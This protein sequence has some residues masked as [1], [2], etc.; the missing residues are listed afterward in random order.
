MARLTQMLRDAILQAAITGKLSCQN[1][2]D[3]SVNDLLESIH[4]EKTT[5]I[6]ERK[7]PKEKKL[8][9]ISKEE[10]NILSIPPHWKLVRVQDIASFITDYV[11]NGSFKTLKEHT[12]TYESKNY[13]VFVR[14][15][16]LT[17]DFKGQ[18]SY[19]DKESYD[20]LSKSKLHGGELIL[21]NIGGSIGKVFLMPDLGMPMSLAPNSIMLKLLYPVMNKYF[22]CIVKAPY[23]QDMLL[24]TKGGTAT[25]KFSKTELRYM[26]VPIPPIEEQQRI[27]DRVDE[28]M[29]KI[30]E[31]EVIENELE[32]LKA[33][34]PGEMK[35]A[36]LQAAMEGK[37]TDQEANDYS[38]KEL[39]EEMDFAR[40]EGIKNKEVKKEK[41]DPIEDVLFD[42]PL[43][44]SW[45]RLGAVANLKM[46]KTPP[47]AE[48]KW[49]GADYKWVSISDMIQDGIIMDTKESISKAGFEEKFKS[50]LSPIGTLLMSFKLTIGKMSI[51][52]INAVH[53]EAI[54]SIFPYSRS[55]SVIRNYLF[56]V[57]PYLSKYGDT[58][59]AI[60]GNT[61]NAKSLNNLLVPL[62]P[63]KEQERIVDRL[64]SLLPLCN[65]LEELNYEGR[66]I[67]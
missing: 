25:P 60:K 46:G 7:I 3:S 32:A 16:D 52:G 61:L 33:D 1:E 35:E 30:D 20:F 37:L 64:D 15:V 40:E 39:C 34:F 11:A 56:K 55:D 63:I 10:A 31:F 49:W 48:S 24:K 51:L 41:L 26:I 4:V 5:L 45:T 36:L 12:T 2:G 23:G 47:R 19:I 57:L 65:S 53:N 43:N 14:T 13:A 9:D 28:L 50:R 54:V 42:I 58:K 8:P 44:W 21:P 67:V 29:A 18:C 22:S 59:G 27:V 38:V 62:P 66:S 17:N 6:N